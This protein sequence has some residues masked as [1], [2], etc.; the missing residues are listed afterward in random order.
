MCKRNDF[1]VRDKD[2]GF[3]QPLQM[4]HNLTHNLNLAQLFYHTHQLEVANYS[5][6]NYLNFHTVSDG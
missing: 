4:E 5:N 1:T 2:T 6:P 3:V